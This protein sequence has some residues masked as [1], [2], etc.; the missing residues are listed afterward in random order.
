MLRLIFLRFWPVL[1]IIL[2]AILWRQWIKR[3]RN[4]VVP[5]QE[6][7]ERSLVR[8]LT[9]I[10][11]VVFLCFSWI[12]IEVVSDHQQTYRAKQFRDGKIQPS[13]D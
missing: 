10:T 11:T 5:T 12:I 4:G 3:P 2:T 7:L 6:I 1:L 9:A 13:I 8:W